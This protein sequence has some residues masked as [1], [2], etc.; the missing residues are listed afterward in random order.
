MNSSQHLSDFDRII[1]NRIQSGFPLEKEPYTVLAAD[2]GESDKTVYT[3]CCTLREK[4]IIRRIGA[5]YVPG[6]LGYTTTLAAARVDQEM[7]EDAAACAG[8]FPEVTH[9][10]ERDHQLNLWFTI[11]A[12]SE[13]RLN[14]IISQVGSK[15]GVQ[16][17]YTLP[18]C[19]NYKLKVE[20]KFREPGNSDKGPKINTAGDNGQSSAANIILNPDKKLIARSCGD[21]DNSLM[22][23]ESMAKDVGIAE[24]NLLNRL[25]DYRKQGV[26][27]RF[28]AILQHQ[29]AGFK[30]NGM[31][32]WSIPADQVKMAAECLSAKP[33]VSHCYERKAVPDWPYNL[34]AMIH[35]Q[36][37][38]EVRSL[39]Q[40]LSEEINIQDYQILFSI[41]EF[42]KSSMVYFG[43]EI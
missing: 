29:T 31:S 26:L 16:K 14:Y 28:G 9:N 39:C 41:R 8:S 5:I 13:D 20:F 42:K 18:S 35:K 27:R 17:I 4:G 11:I 2:L 38:E 15:K 25:K 34:Y 6:R 33:E 7:L 40:N 22:P 37:K 32:V 1:L 30:G 10:Y 36:N 23:F 24:E 12:S 43:E 19:G 21:I 3:A